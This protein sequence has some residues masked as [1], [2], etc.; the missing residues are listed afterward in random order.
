MARDVLTCGTTLRGKDELATVG[1]HV[2][3]SAAKLQN[4]A[5]SLNTLINGVR[6]VSG[7]LRSVATA[8]TQRGAGLDETTENVG[9]LDKTTRN[10]AALVELTMAHI[11]DAGQ[12]QTFTGCRSPADVDVDCGLSIFVAD[13]IGFIR[14][15]GA[16][17][18]LVGRH[19]RADR[20]AA[21]RPGKPALL[22]ASGL[23]LKDS[24]PMPT[25]QHAP[26]LRCIAPE[27]TANSGAGHRHQP[28]QPALGDAR[29]AGPD[30]RA[31]GNI[32]APT[33]S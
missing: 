9:N 12:D 14:V 6:D 27:R 8:G 3:T 10:N 17:P 2:D 28:P 29:H 26:R 4:V 15:P 31:D 32:A 1:R 33:W 25:L 22:V 5:G 20:L 21:A 30:R 24:G 23:A 11:A 18:A 13:H 7:R 19:E 16:K